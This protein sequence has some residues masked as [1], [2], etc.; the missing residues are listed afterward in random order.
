MKV[1][2]CPYCGK[3]ISYVNAYS[4]RRKAE[5]VCERC[6]KESKVVIDRKVI[7]VFVL[8]AVISGA[9]MAGWIFAGL[10]HNALGIL[11]VAIPLIAFAVISPR[12]VNYQPFNKYRKS[13]EAKKAGIEYSDNL[14]VSEIE[15]AEAPIY[16]TAQNFQINTDVFNKIRADRNAARA[17]LK[18]NDS[19]ISSSSKVSFEKND[20][21]DTKKD[22]FV[23]VI[24]DVRENHSSA[25]APL[26]RLN[27]EPPRPKRS[28]HYVAPAHEEKQER[29]SDTNRYSSNR[30]F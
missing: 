1:K 20:F 5:Y 2:K 4:S 16:D 13:M 28:H 23:P 26:K 11:L 25:D 10:S 12:F 21:S 8:C 7:L 15:E 30:R 27:T 14:A 3:K 6:Q 19:E 22:E 18:E 17:K 9:I 29:K 24:D